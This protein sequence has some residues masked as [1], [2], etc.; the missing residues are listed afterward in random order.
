MTALRV[1]FSPRNPSVPPVPCG[2]SRSHCVAA[3][4]SKRY[5]SAL[6]TFSDNCCSGVM[7]SMIQSPRPIVATIRSLSR[8]WIAMSWIDTVGR[9]L[10]R[11]AHF[12]PPSIE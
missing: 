12:F 10:F 3:R 6:V 11:R 9:L 2:W 4:F 8:G 7:S 5:A 1:G